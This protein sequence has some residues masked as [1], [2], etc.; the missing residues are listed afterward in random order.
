[1]FY[2]IFFTSQVKRS[3][4]ISIERVASRVAERLKT[5]ERSKKIRKDQENFK[6][7]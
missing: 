3:V 4:I 1:M 7:S 2:Q 6:T 5:Y